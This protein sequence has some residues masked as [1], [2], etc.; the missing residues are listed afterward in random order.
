MY[1]CVSARAQI[2]LFMNG[3]PNN[4]CKVVTK[5]FALLGCSIYLLEMTDFFY[6]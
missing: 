6:C 4:S 2:H 3:L 5:K 1:V